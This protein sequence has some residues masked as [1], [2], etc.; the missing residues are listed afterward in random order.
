MKTMTEQFQITEYS[1]TAAALSELRNR[2]TGPFDVATSK[3]MALAK[4]ARAVVRGYRTSLETLRKEI[5]APA[6]ER[7]RL[8]DDEAKRITAELLKI[9]EPIDTAIKA[10]ERRKEEEKAAK[11]KAEA[12]RVA[13]IQARINA[14][15][16]RANAVANKSAAEIRAALEQVDAIKLLEDDFDKLLGCDFEEFL[17]DA[18]KAFDETLDTLKNLLI[19]RVAFEEEQA[20]QQAEREAEAA[21]LRA[22]REELARLR[23]EEMARQAE[24][25]RIE[26]EAR[27]IEEARLKAERAALE[28][29]LRAQREEQERQEQEARKAIEAEEA[30]QRAEREAMERFNSELAERQ[31]QI[32]KAEQERQHRIEEAAR[33]EA[34]R[35]SQAAKAKAP[36][37][38]LAGLKKALA[39]G[40]ITA[41][42][43]L[44]QAYQIGFNAGLQSAQQAL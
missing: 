43:A 10:E 15:R 3:G 35:Q 25:A 21:R 18:I 7:C 1:T 9:E 4:E 17:P 42:V 31:R 8:I 13:T 19:E 5:K 6:L 41:T 11:A 37:D 23:A 44:D 40:E 28:S 39:A 24:Q 16:N 30:R 26:A 33:L 32:E 36:A 20:R 38:Q 27:K 2:Y 34:E 29:E 12:E 14:I 22:E